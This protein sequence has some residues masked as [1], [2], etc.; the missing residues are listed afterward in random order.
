M[1]RCAGRDGDANLG[2]RGV[3]YARRRGRWDCASGDGDGR[4][5]RLAPPPPP[6]GRSPSPAS[7]GRM[8]TPVNPSTA[9]TNNPSSPPRARPVE[10]QEVSDRPDEGVGAVG[11]VA[12]GPP[13]EVGG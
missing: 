5:S 4:G 7:W 10:P 3:G 12:G 13:V 6:F 9:P 8:S 11:G 1:A 2:R